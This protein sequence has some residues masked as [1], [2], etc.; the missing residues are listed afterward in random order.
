MRVKDGVVFLSGQTRLDAD[1]QWAGEL[2]RSTQD[3]V[4]VVITSMWLSPRLGTNSNR[5]PPACRNSAR[6]DSRVL[7][8][9]A[10]ILLLAYFAAAV[11]VRWARHGLT[12]RV[13]AGLLREV[14]AR[15]F[16]FVVLLFG[17][18]LTLRIANLTHLALTVVGG[19]GLIGLVVGIAF[20]NITENFLA[21]IF[22]SMQRP[23]Q[24]GDLVEIAGT[25]GYVQRLTTRTT[26]MITLDGNE[27]Q[28]PQRH[29]L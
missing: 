28:I 3:V 6:H 19:T 25:L 21:S 15:A 11:A 4:A 10:L 20:G 29:R 5:R 16:G 23:F 9:G 14:L 24:A 26:V 8:S 1:K 13:P 22:L 17:L 27:V 7:I 2:A 12:R 18:Y